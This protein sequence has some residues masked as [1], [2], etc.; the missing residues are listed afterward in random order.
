MCVCTGGRLDGA[1]QGR[2]RGIYM[3]VAHLDGLRYVLCGLLYLKETGYIRYIRYDTITLGQL[4]SIER[5]RVSRV[6]AIAEIR[7]GRR[8]WRRSSR[9]ISFGECI[10]RLEFSELMREEKI[11]NLG[12]Q[13]GKDRTCMLI[14][15]ISS[16]CD[17]CKTLSGGTFTLNQIIP[18]DAL[19]VTKGGDNL[20]KYTYYGESGGF[21]VFFPFQGIIGTCASEL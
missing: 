5:C 19:N 11:V 18:K 16:H 20:G 7:S 8:S 12:E 4:S 14:I 10:L 3:G 21:P 17:T 1:G 9:D 15:V 13:L 6:I 2:G